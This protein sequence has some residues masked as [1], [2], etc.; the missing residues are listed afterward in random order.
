MT[1]RWSPPYTYS[2]LCDLFGFDHGEIVM[3]AEV[4]MLRG[5]SAQ[6]TARFSVYGLGHRYLASD[7]LTQAETAHKLQGST[8]PPDCEDWSER[9]TTLYLVQHELPD[10]Y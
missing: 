9:H 2:E 5:Q 8:L 10:S 7:V 1:F 4:G 6:G 3:L